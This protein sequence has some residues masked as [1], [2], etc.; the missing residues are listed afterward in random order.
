MAGGEIGSLGIFDHLP[1]GLG[2]SSLRRDILNPDSRRPLRLGKLRRA[3]KNTEEN[4][5]NEEQQL[6]ATAERSGAATKSSSSSFSSSP[7]TAP[8]PMTRTR[9]RDSRGLRRFGQIRIERD[10]NPRVCG[11]CA[12]CAFGFRV[13]FGIRHS[14]FVIVR[15]LPESTSEHHRCPATLTAAPPAKS[16][17]V[18][19]AV[20]GK[21][22]RRRCARIVRR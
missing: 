7:S 8:F 20:A 15:C 5:G 14:D 13:S 4:E 12:S 1:A 11:R 18:P 17:V 6:C 21:E 10:P 16:P 2:A 19:A 22:C 9:T 3:E